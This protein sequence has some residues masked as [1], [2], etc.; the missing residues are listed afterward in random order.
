M[1]GEGS[2]EKVTE[3]T[4]PK[5][6]KLVH[7]RAYLPNTFIICL[8]ASPWRKHSHRRLSHGGRA[9]ESRHGIAELEETM[10]RV[11]AL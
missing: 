10:L 7:V 8:F 9:T 11:L 3:A 6:G 2:W 4:S 1:A 5:V